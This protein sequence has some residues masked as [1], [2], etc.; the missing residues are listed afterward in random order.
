[1]R[2]ANIQQTGANTRTGME[3]A[4]RQSVANA[5]I[6]GRQKV[7]ET[8]EGGATTR[9]G[10]EP[11]TYADPDNPTQSTT[12]PL[13]TMIAKPG[14]VRS[15]TPTAIPEAVKPTEVQPAGPGGPTFNQP[16]FQTQRNQTPTY[17]PV[18]EQQQGAPGQYINLDNPTQLVPATFAQAQASN[19]R[20]VPV[21]KNADEWNALAASA[22]ANAKTPEE[23]QKIRDRVLQFGQTIQPK[24]ADAVETLRNQNII[25]SQLEKAV[26][27]PAGT[28][29][30][31]N[32]HPTAASPELGTTLSNLTDEYFRNGGPAVRGDRIAATNAAIQ[33]LISQKLIDPNQSRALGLT[34]NTSIIKNIQQKTGNYLAQP[35]FRLDITDPATGKVA[36][37]GHAPVIHMA[38]SLASTVVPNNTPV[39]AT[40]QPIADAPPGAPDGRR[41]QLPDGRVGVVRGGKVYAQ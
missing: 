29:P 13:S 11:F 30:M 17:Q 27:V 4:G 24:P 9:K 36:E 32:T 33:Q 15:Y 39:P 5:E 6:A 10:M 38:P 40:N 23:A 26:P 7:T 3:V 22:A 8:M 18:Q 1:M 25:D 41:A 37:A 12:V 31:L 19:G 21:P 28:H 35:R 16:A 2:V 14:G 20:I 34:G